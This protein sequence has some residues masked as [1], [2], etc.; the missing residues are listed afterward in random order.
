MAVRRRIRR[1]FRGK[2]PSWFLAFCLKV[3]RSLVNHFYFTE[4]RWGSNFAILQKFF[5]LVDKFQGAFHLASNGDRVLIRERDNLAEEILAL[6]DQ[7]ASNLESMA[8]GNFDALL[9]TGFSVTQERRNTPRIKLPLG[10]AN[11]FSVSNA[12]ESGKAVGKASN[13]PGAFNNEIHFTRNDPSVEENWMHK[14]IFP[15]ATE[16]V[17]ENLEPGNTFFRMRP[18]GPDGPGPWSPVTST[19]IT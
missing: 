15:D 19:P 16:M 4:A 9:T 1:D 17:M 11:D 2:A 5:E 12:P 3:K 13:V 7:M 6:L 18:H 10:A 14:A 8:A